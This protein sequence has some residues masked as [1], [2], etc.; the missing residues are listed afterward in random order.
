MSNRAVCFFHELF[1][2]GSAAV[3]GGKG[4]TLSRLRRAG[5]PVPDGFVVLF[6]A[7]EGDALSPTAR[8]SVLQAARALRAS[9]GNSSF[10]VRSSAEQEDSARTSFAGAFETVLDVSSDEDLLQAVERVRRSRHS[11]RAASYAE[12]RGGAAAQ[13]M[14]VV[15]QHLV[16]ADVSGVLFTADPVTGDR[17][18]MAGNAVRGL[19][20]ALVSGEATA[21]TFTLRK[22]RGAYTGPKALGRYAR[23]LFQLGRRLE[24]E[25]GSPQ[26]I[27]WAVAGGRAAILQARAITTLRPEDPVTGERN[28]SYSGD[29]LW[30][31]ANV[32]EAF[33]GA[34]TPCTWSLVQRAFRVLLPMLFVEGHQPMGLIAGRVYFNYSLML[35]MGAAFGVSPRRFGAQVASVFGRIPEGLE[36]PRVPL[37]A[38]RLLAGTL[39]HAWR[40]RVGARR[41][42]AFLGR[43]AARC[44]ELRARIAAAADVRELEAIWHGELSP[45][46]Q[47]SFQLVMATANASGDL[48]AKLR[49]QLPALVGDEDAAALC[50]HGSTGAEALA[51]L[52]PLIGLE[53]LARGEIDRDAY[54]RAWGHRGPD[55]LELSI[56]RPAED[57]A[58]LERQIAAARTAT[59][60]GL[61]LL[62]RQVERHAAARERLR[63]RHPIRAMFLLRRLDR[64]ARAARDRELARSET[65]RASSVTRAWVL[66]AGVLT[67]HGDALFF[68]SADEILAVMSGEQAPLAHVPARRAIYER[69]RALPPLPGLIRGRFDPYQWAADPG[70][71]TDLFDARGGPAP[72]GDAISGFPGASG[73]VEGE[74]RVLASFADGEQ[75][76]RGEILVTASTNVGWTPLFPRAAAIVTDVGAPLSHAAIV[77]RELGIPAVVG[78]GNAT[79]L[80]RTG[81]RVRVNGARG[82]V[83]RVEPAPAAR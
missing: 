20:E 34:M 51:S 30:T 80:L 74:V 38:W 40:S 22:P 70:R 17:G 41:L 45:F 28:D 72:S 42:S 67:G 81:D 10:A 48:A 31:N 25:L 36:V 82:T 33:I 5:Y 75:L 46:N 4:N 16:R 59:E 64:A 12:A 15:V 60:S 83:E 68:L 26:D 56:P 32:G 52:G 58:W 29:Y 19:G 73:V 13:E 66:R 27:E 44:D 57:P 63:R 78:C 8:D 35:E 53:R 71:R 49:N 69:Q 37:P 18:A 54:V 9:A 6:T 43:S 76:R 50:S 62:Q 14:A 23:Q 1:G 24:R 79:A 77:A 61:S 55:E 21:S 65:V 11:A 47:E 2:T 39:W 3:A 7:F